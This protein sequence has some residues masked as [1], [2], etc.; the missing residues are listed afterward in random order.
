MLDTRG[1]LGHAWG[2]TSLAREERLRLASLLRKVG[3]GAP[4]L[5]E[6][7]DTRDLAVHLVMRDRDLPALVGEHLKLF[8]KRHERVDELLRDTPWIE[9]VG[10]I[11]QGP[12]AW[13]PSSWGVGVDSL[14]NTA[15]FLIHHEDVRRAQPGWRARELGTQV[16]K[17]ML[18]LVRALAL[19]YAIRQ[20]LHV[21]LQPR[22][23]DPFRAGRTNKTTVTVTGMPI[24]LLLYLFGRESHAVVDVRE[25]A[26]VSDDEDAEVVGGTPDEVAAAESDSVAGEWPAAVQHQKKKRGPIVERPEGS[27]I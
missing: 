18:P 1:P 4:T 21:V 22:G 11:A 19:S 12:T 2:M 10:K 23:F 14:M 7:W 27:E 8:A 9:L 24:E 26:P 6:G 3:P 17:D 13:N 20:G 25:S 15:E 5:C 16:Q